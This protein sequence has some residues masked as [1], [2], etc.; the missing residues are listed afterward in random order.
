MVTKLELDFDLLTPANDPYPPE[1]KLVPDNKH[2]A[3]LVNEAQIQVE[4]GTNP[5]YGEVTW[6][7]LICADKTPSTEFILGVAKFKPGERLH[8]HRHEPAEFYYCTA[9]TGEVVIEGDVYS[10]HEGMAVYLPPN[11]EHSVTAGPNGFS[12]LYGFAEARFSA[13]KYQFSEI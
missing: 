10:V 9:G 7:T 11:A 4:G 5:M 6:R 3:F 2:K 13:V 12:M 8:A 1:L